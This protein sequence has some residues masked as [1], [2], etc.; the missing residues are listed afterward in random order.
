MLDKENK[1]CDKTQKEQS[2]QELERRLEAISGELDASNNPLL[3]KISE[4]NKDK[5]RAEYIISEL[6]AGIVFGIVLGMFL[7]DYFSTAPIFL[8]SLIIL[9]LAGSF[10]NIYKDACK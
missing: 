9:G 1:E 3:K 10:Y 7:D 6:I 5:F 4:N 8:L 2:L